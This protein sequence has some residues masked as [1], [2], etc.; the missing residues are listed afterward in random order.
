MG[1][2]CFRLWIV[3]A[4]SFA[5]QLSALGPAQAAQD[6][7]VIDVFE[8]AKSGDLLLIPVD[9]GE[10]HCSFILDTGSSVNVIDAKFRDALVPIGKNGRINGSGSSQLYVSPGV[11]VGSRGLQLVGRALST[12]LS[13]FKNASGQN[14][15]GIVGMEFLRSYVVQIDFDKGRVSLLK[16]SEHVAGVRTPM[17]FKLMVPTIDVDLPVVGKIPFAIDTGCIGFRNGQLK[18]DI[19]DTL[20]AAK[21]VSI[22]DATTVDRT[23][24]GDIENQIGI[25]AEQ[26]VG[27]LRHDSQVY[28][29]GTVNLLGNG[30]LSRYTVTF[31][32]PKR[33]LVMQR[34]K[35][36]S[37]TAAISRASIDLVTV[38][39]A[40]IVRDIDP[41]SFAWRSG[42]RQGDRI[43]AVV[44]NDRDEMT[45]FSVADLLDRLPG[46]VVIK[47]L[48]PGSKTIHE[49][50]MD[51]TPAV[52]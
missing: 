32:F 2:N 10:R 20:V 47:V 24:E 40:L 7:N 1:A 16:N 13:G 45:L 36:F 35:R 34:G 52:N 5:A 44:G 15:D 41:D 12:D 4:L 39:G 14:I 43:V 30:Y 17:T 25:L 23:A 29:T 31:D 21:Q 9:V 37:W 42:M 48:R 49:I 38:D 28:T 51:R 50:R 22:L 26:S 19:F 18:R 6:E 27:D 46:D 3:V 33:I 11:S 8:V